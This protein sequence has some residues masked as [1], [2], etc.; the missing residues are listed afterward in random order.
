VLEHRLA[1]AAFTVTLTSDTGAS[2]GTNQGDFRYCLSNA[3]ANDSIQF[4]ATGTI[5]LESALPIIQVPLNIIGPGADKLTIQRDQATEAFG[6]F[7]VN[8]GIAVNI[9]GLR[10]TGGNSMQGGAIDTFGALDVVNCTI[11]HNTATL[12]GGG[13]IAIEPGGSLVL[14]DSYISGNTAPASGSLGGGVYSD[15]GYVTMVNSSFDSNSAS[16]GGGFGIAGIDYSP[17]ATL[18]NCTFFNSAATGA[19]RGGGA[20]AVNAYSQP[21]AVQLNSCT[22][23]NNS[24]AGTTGGVALYGGDSIHSSVGYQ[25]CIFAN[26]SGSNLYC[27]TSGGFQGTLSSGG[28]NLSTDNSGNLNPGMGDLPSANPALGPLGN[29]GGPVP[30]IS[31]LPESQAIGK[32]VSISGLTFDARGM[33]RA[34]TIDIGAFQTQA[35]PLLVNTIDDTAT[36]AEPRGQLSL[37]NAID[38]ANVLSSDNVPCNVTFDP[39]VFSTPQSILLT[40]GQLEIASSMTIDGP[41]TGVTIDGKGA[42]SVVRVDGGAQATMANLTL[43]DGGS[44]SYGGGLYNDG[45]TVTLTDSTIRDNGTSDGAGLYNTS[46]GTVYLTGCTISGNSA[47]NNGAGLFNNSGSVTLTNCTVANNNG[48]IGSGTGLY[49]GDANLTL[50]N[51]TV[52]GNYTAVNPNGVGVYTAGGPLTLDNTIVAGNKSGAA[53]VTQ[54]VGSYSGGNDLVNQS[55]A[56]V[57]LDPNGLRDNGGPTATFALVPGGPAIDAGSNALIPGGITTDQRGQLRI[58][59]GAVDIGAFEDQVTVTAP[60]RPESA[61]E[62]FSSSFALGSF[63]DTSVLPPAGW[64]VSVDWGDETIQ[65]DFSV[66]SSG[67][68][69]TQTHDYTAPGTYTVTVTVTGAMGNAGQ[70]TFNVT[71]FDAALA[72]GTSLANFTDFSSTANLTLDGSATQAVYNGADVLRLTSSSGGTGAAFFNTPVSLTQTFESQFQFD[73]HDTSTNPGDGFTFI[74]QN[75]PRGTSAAGGGGGGLGYLGITPSL[76]VEFDI[77]DN[78]PNDQ[79]SRNHVALFTNGNLNDTALT[80]PGFFF[81]DSGPV[82]AWVDYDPTTH[83]LT[84]YASQSTVKPATPVISYTYDLAANVGSSAYFGFSGATGANNADQDIQ[85]WQVVGSAA[86]AGG[87]ET[88]ANSSVLA[89]ATFT[90]T[91]P[92]DHSAEMTAVIDWGDGSPTSTGSVTS[93]PVMGLYT[94]SGAHTYAEEGTYDISIAVSDAG[95]RMLTLTGVATVGDA[96]LTAGGSSIEA[97]EFGTVTQG[98]FAGT[99]YLGYQF[100]VSSPI[101]VTALGSYFAPPAS[102]ML[103]A[104]YPDSSSTPVVSATVLASDPVTGNFNYHTLSSPV[105]LGPGTYIVAAQYPS[106]DFARLVSGLTIAPGI[107]YQNA[108]FGTPGSFNSDPGIQDIGGTFQ[109]VAAPTATGGVEGVTAATLSNANFNDANIGAASMD[110]TVTA[111]SWGDGSTATAGLA[112]TGNNGTYA[113]TGSHL[114]AEEGTYDFSLTV[115]DD[116]GQTVI[117]TGST[118]IDDAPLTPGTGSASGG[119][120]HTTPTVLSATFTDTNFAAPASDFSGTIDWGDGTAGNPDV[121]TFNSGAVTASESRYTISSSHQYA[122]QGS[123]NITVVINDLDGS[124]TTDT[125]TATVGDAPLTSGTV[126]AAGGVEYATATALTATFTDANLAALPADFSGTIDWGDGTAGSPDITNFTSS[127]VAGSG[128]S[129]TVS[130]NHQSAEQGTYN[131]TVVVNDVDGSSTTVIGSTS[132]A[133]APLTAGSINAGG[134]VEFTTATTLSATFTDANLAAPSSDFSGTIDWGDGTVGHPDFTTFTSSYVAGSE[135]GYTISNSHQYAEQ[136]NYNITIAVNDVDGSAITLTGSTIVADAPLLPGTVNASGGAE[137]TTPTTL[138]ASFTDTNLAARAS[139]FSGTIDW[140]DGSAGHPDVTTFTSGAVAAV[141]GGYTISSNHQY[142]EQ[143]NYSITV[144][145]NDADGSSTNITGSTTVA[146]APLTPGTVSASGGVELTK[147]TTLAATVTDANPAALAGDFSGSINW[148]D[149][150]EGSVFDSSAVSGSAGNYT[151]SASHQYTEQGNYTITVTIFDVDGS[152]TVV[153]GS[154]T[155]AD[156]PLTAGTVNASGGVEYTNPTTLGA[157]FTDTGGIETPIVGGPAPAHWY[158]GENNANDSAGGPAGTIKGQVGFL[159]GQVGQAFNLPGNGGVAGSSPSVSYPAS[160]FAPG[161][162]D[163]SVAFG[164]ATTYNPPF[165]HPE[166]VLGDRSDSSAGNFF[167]VRITASGQLVVELYQDSLGTNAVGLTSTFAINDGQFHYF[168]ITRSGTTASLYIDGSLNVTKQ[169]AGVTNLTANGGANAFQLGAEQGSAATFT[170]PLTGLLDEVQIY[171]QALTPAQVAA[172]NSAFQAGTT[173]QG[174]YLATIDWGDGTPGTAGTVSYDPSTQTFTVSGSHQYAEDG[175]Y[176]VAVVVN[177]DGGSSTTIS[178]TT[179]VG[180][181][182]LTAGTLAISDSTEYTTAATLNATF[183]DTNHSALPADF[184]GTIDWGDGTAVTTF[185]SSVVAGSDSGFTVS[186]S[187][188]YAAQGTYTVTVAIHDAGDSSA[189][190]TGSASVADASLSAGTITTAGGVKNVTPTTLR[191][192]FTDANLAALAADFSG[193]IGWGDTSPITT[194]D[195]TAVT[196]SRG[197]YAVNAS[198]AYSHEGNYFITVVVNDAGGSSTTVTGS[199]TVTNPAVLPVALPPVKTIAELPFTGLVV[200]AFADP[201]GAEIDPETPDLSIS[202]FY[203]VAS[204]DWGDGTPLDTTSGTISYFGGPGSTTSSFFVA[205]NHAYAVAGTYTITAVIQHPSAP[206]TKLFSTITVLPA[207][208]VFLGGDAIVN[209][210]DTFQRTGSFVDFTQS[211]PRSQDTAPPA[212]DSLTVDYGGGMPVQGVTFDATNHFTLSHVFGQEGAFRVTVTLVDSLGGVTKASFVVNVLLA[213]VVPSTVISVPPGQVETISIDGQTVSGSGKNQDVTSAS[214]TLTVEQPPG[215]TLP[216]ELIASVVPRNTDAKLN[217][218]SFLLQSGLAVTAFDVRVLNATTGAEAQIV[219]HYGSVSLAEPTLLYYDEATDLQEPITLDGETVDPVN[220]LITGYLDFNSTPRLVDLDG[221]VFTIVVPLQPT[222]AP[223]LGAVDLQG[224]EVNISP[225]GASSSPA[226]NGGKGD[227]S[228]ATSTGRVVQASFLLTQGPTGS[229]DPDTRP[230]AGDG[231]PLAEL[232]PVAP[233]VLGPGSAAIAPATVGKPPQTKPAPT[234]APQT[235]ANE[236]E[237]DETDPSSEVGLYPEGVVF[238]S[239][240]SRSAPW[241]ADA[242]ARIADACATDTWVADARITDTRITGAPDADARHVGGQDGN[243]RDADV[244]DLAATDLSLRDAAFATLV[245]RNTLSDSGLFL[246]M[247]AMA[248]LGDRVPEWWDRPRVRKE[249][250]RPIR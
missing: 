75:D 103:A 193:T 201:G 120:E 49:D 22:I 232:P 39:A 116:G 10:L 43:T 61:I 128:G 11:D 143:G 208:Q 80:D 230:G 144:T 222:P 73:L 154:T 47:Y 227:S 235:G 141:E 28:N 71:V 178:G 55:A 57:G 196:G 151:V 165:G 6:L 87:T 66:G 225:Q 48:T 94:V 156:A 34:G 237:S 111:A 5:T 92:G 121:T 117:I 52:A 23:A 44:V 163:F 1:P 211:A 198:H 25:D 169:S 53:G 96:T 171:S 250:P 189:S 101:T 226:E 31:L 243:A 106:T 197:S 59:N 231:G 146:D 194:F 38:L 147:A 69:P 145:V 127:A 206:A 209:V 229:P 219:F 168:V 13:G 54:V 167:G 8:A 190:L 46:G 212:S 126:S 177:D 15:D 114:Y 125:G 24:S 184:F 3:G 183:T 240:G 204:I 223:D 202:A 188:Q 67:T 4:A 241:G 88:T 29:Y 78:E 140:G 79:H 36:G 203:Q 51:C 104:I 221:T 166:V 60:A 99:V 37:R 137:F 112:V 139:D 136:G 205:G 119:I 16:S 40:G 20:I 131:I 90:Y 58:S 180:D 122:G 155:V 41:A 218:S 133:D 7:N 109:Y 210:G 238:H 129:Y 70:A 175:T 195:S 248:L 185:D 216:L 186:S 215:S 244:Q 17:T 159:A 134:G 115:T 72:P 135:A 158:R 35:S 138:S 26:N 107:S 100:A 200:A 63:F 89:N 85:S 14:K 74:V 187:H 160:D 32:G 95:G 98:A 172:R 242:D 82:N 68:M 97:E 124:T 239:P 174:E 142:A 42:S 108:V 30:T 91:N 220:H 162:G 45:G 249:S 33:N 19:G 77:V 234:S 113:V 173:G 213:G 224:Y 123:Y 182:S 150:T 192:A 164:L 191:A 12:G 105:V 18:D 236:E 50:I 130:D 110:F 233:P 199:T 161:T 246:V 81:Y 64:S 84:V 214:L 65:D 152:S 9:S 76:A 2:S 245:H 27:D 21:V 157:T 83:L 170:I 217:D 86:T 176:P 148:G 181:A 118:V 207:S 93:N 247:A 132:V 62:N 228:A 179:T 56:A 102:S 153:M 149:G